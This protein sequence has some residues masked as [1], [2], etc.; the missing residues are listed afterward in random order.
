MVPE[1]SVVCK[2][3][4]PCGTGR[5]SPTAWGGGRTCAPNSARQ[6]RRRAV[7]RPPAGHIP[8]KSTPNF[9]SGTRAVTCSFQGREIAAP[10]P[11]GEPESRPTHPKLCLT[12]VGG[13]QSCKAHTVSRGGACWSRRHSGGDESSATCEV[14]RKNGASAYATVKLRRVRIRSGCLGGSN[15]TESLYAHR[16]NFSV[17]EAQALDRGGRGRWRLS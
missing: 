1:G 8:A 10:P 7:G 11:N 14:R 12:P 5:P 2:G 16:V 9:I 13:L 3:E 15:R 17:K 4:Q 6:I